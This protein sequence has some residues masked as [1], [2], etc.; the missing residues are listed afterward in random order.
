MNIVEA[1]RTY[2]VSSPKIRIGNEHDGGYVVNELITA[3]TKKLI[4][5]GMGNDDGF[6]RAWFSK[7]QT[8]IEAYDGTYP[9][10]TICSLYHEHVN[11]K[12]FYVKHNV[13][14]GESLIPL[15]TI[16]DGKPDVLL[17]VDVEGAE[18]EIFDN[19]KLETVTG[20]ILEVHDLHVTEKQTKLIELIKNNFSNL[21]LFHIHGNS[22][23]N[24]FTLNLSRTGIRG[25]E[26]KEFPYVMELCFINK[27]LVHQYELET[28]TFPIAQ[29]DTSNNCD[30]SDIDLYWV[31]AL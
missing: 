20:L 28:T 27:Q 29:L 2:N 4:S 15:N 18:Y 19:I 1:L 3:H 12:I 8:E 22:W 13:G 14:Y 7:Y 9:C 6:E 31:N 11:K 23:A 26:L 17:K 10:Q 24:T 16:V 21:M 30:V 25:L 5:I